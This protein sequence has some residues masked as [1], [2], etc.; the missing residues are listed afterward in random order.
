[1]RPSFR[2]QIV[3]LDEQPV[4]ALKCF[5]HGED[6]GFH[7]MHP[8]L[9]VVPQH[10][11]VGIQPLAGELLSSWLRRVADANATTLE[12][13]LAAVSR[14]D[15]IFSDDNMG[16]DYQLPEEIRQRLSVFCRIPAATIAEL[17]IRNAF[18][19][20]RPE[21]FYGRHHSISSPSESTLLPAVLGGAGS[22]WMSA[23]RSSSVGRA[24]LHSLYVTL[25]AIPGFL[26]FLLD[27]RSCGVARYR[28]TSTN[29]M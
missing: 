20:H 27:Q 21:W 17:E 7:M 29:I 25:V 22:E 5:A 14:A 23:A 26:Q 3:E 11:P 16:F 2:S 12:E 6:S 13:L 9:V 10:L 24:S 8:R 19:G 4:E 18:V 1:M 28:A 15:S